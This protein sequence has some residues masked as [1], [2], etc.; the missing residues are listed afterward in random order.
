MDTTWTPTHIDQ[1]LPPLSQVVA[2]LH[3]PHPNNRQFHRRR[4]AHVLDESGTLY[5]HIHGDP[6]W[7]LTQ[8]Q[9]ITHW[10]PIPLLP[11]PPEKPGP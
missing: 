6:L 8:L 7:L 9:H 1:N 10:Y 11:E 2:V 5:W 3:L 4:F